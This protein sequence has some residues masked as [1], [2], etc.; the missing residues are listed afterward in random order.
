MEPGK[1]P[2][3]KADSDEPLTDLVINVSSVV[4]SG[5]LRLRSAPNT[6]SN[7]VKKLP[8]LTPLVVLEPVD[9]ARPKIGV[10]DQWLNV[11][12]SDGAAGYVAAWYVTS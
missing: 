9:A 11:R 2:E 3:Q 6:K 4:G 12:T 10:M 5:G 7:I 1:L 8:P